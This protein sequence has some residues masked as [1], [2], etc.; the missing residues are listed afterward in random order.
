[1][2]IF[3]IGAT[4]PFT[5]EPP[6]VARKAVEDKVLAAASFGIRAMVIRPRLIRGPGDHG[7]VPMVCRSVAATGRP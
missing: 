1:M 3:I 5:A 7:H 2:E 6:A 4:G